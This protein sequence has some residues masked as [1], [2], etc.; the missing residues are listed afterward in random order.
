MSDLLSKLSD[1]IE[2]SG[3]KVTFGLQPHHIERIESERKRWNKEHGFD[4]IYANH[5]W[6]GLGKEFAWDSLTLAL[7]Y[8]HYIQQG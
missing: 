8:F 6:I 2:K 5:F 3:C 7:Y 4:V 1:A